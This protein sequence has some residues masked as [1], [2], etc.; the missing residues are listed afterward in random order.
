MERPPPA[1]PASLP[2]W[3]MLFGFVTAA[4]AVKVSVVAESIQVVRG[5]SA[6]LP[7]S[8]H[9]TAPL[10]RLSIIWTVA[11]SSDP[12]QPRQVLAYVQGEVLESLSHYTGRVAFAFSPTQSATIVLNDTRG[13]DSGTYQCSVTNPPDT[14]TPNVGVVRLTVFVPPS[15]PRCWTEGTAD[16]GG[17]LQF[18]CTVE[19]GV[20]LPAFTWEKIP[21]EHTGPLVVSY[22]DD[23]RALLPLPNLTADASGLYRCTASN[24]L[25]SVSCVLEL[26]VRVAP[27]GPTSL[28]VGIALMLSMAV[29]LLALFALG[30]WLHHDSATKWAE[31]GEEEDSHHEI[32]IDTFSL[33][34]LIV[35]KSTPGGDSPVG[36]PPGSK[37]LWI[38]T[39]STPNTTYAHRE[40]RPVP[41]KASQDAPGRWRSASLSERQ[42]SSSGS[43]EKRPTPKPIGFLV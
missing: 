21:P 23:R 8:F 43:E 30:L 37:P 22:E 36:A 41:R 27:S 3:W 18:S 25:G 16:V 35:A 34:R 11:P 39:S 14:S 20:P 5:G 12:G 33:G 17:S 31:G 6:L 9:S 4:G 26:R 10:D 42:E 15:K 24:M 40:W 38:F 29:V 19:E 32:R 7:C 2:G 28:A 13:L 1:C